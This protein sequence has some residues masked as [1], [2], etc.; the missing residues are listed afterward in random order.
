MSPEDRV[1]VT[2]T[3]AQ[4]NAVL[5]MLAEQP[6]RAAFPLIQA[7]QQQCARFDGD[8]GRQQDRVVPVDAIAAQ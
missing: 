8:G 6:Y 7:I 5:A 4:W 2:L 3:A 1:P